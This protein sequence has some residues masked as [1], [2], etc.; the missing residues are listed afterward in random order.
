MNKKIQA[1]ILGASGY[2]GAELV[3]WLLRHPTINI[4][5]LSGD[6]QAGKP[7]GEIYPHFLHTPLPDLQK[8]PDID[9]AAVDVVFCCLPHATTQTIIKQLPDHLKIVDLSADFRLKDVQLYQ[10]WYGKAHQ[11]VELQKQAVYGLTEINREAIRSARLVANPGCYPTASQL[12][13]IPL[14]KRQKILSDHIV[15]DA[16]SGIT[17]AGRKV[18]APGLF[19]E[20]NENFYPYAIGQHR[21]TPE[22]EQGL[23]EAACTEVKLRFTPHLL[24]ISRGIVSTHYV[25]LAE[26]E[27]AESLHKT[28]EDFYA[29]EPFIQ[30]AQAGAPTPSSLQVRGTNHC[31]LGVYK[32][33]LP[34][35]AIVVAAIDNLAKGAASQAIHNMN[36]MLG[37]EET[38]GLQAI[39][40]FP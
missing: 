39:A 5:A 6:S 17:G 33:R 3:R 4:A 34:G 22:I 12:A 13:L 14:L 27:T 10:Q 18:H 38:A 31:L 30:L 9:F 24:P 40:V 23:S 28:L 16:K 11:A 15:I 36:L 21:H 8:I 7:M 37:L 2:T 25:T 32:D 1:A 29:D 26:G 19:A 20:M 35:H